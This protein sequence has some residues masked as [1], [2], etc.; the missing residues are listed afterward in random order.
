MAAHARRAGHVKVTVPAR[1]GAFVV[2]ACADG[3]GK[4]REAGSATTAASPA[5]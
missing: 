2:I 1:S 3:A 4:V 5:G